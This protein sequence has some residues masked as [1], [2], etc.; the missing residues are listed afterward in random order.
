MLPQVNK[1]KVFESVQR[2]G[3]KK[4]V[5]REKGGKRKT[6]RVK[7]RLL[8]WR[9]LHDNFCATSSLANK[10]E[11]DGS[12]MYEC[13]HKKTQKNKRKRNKTK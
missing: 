4:N 8:L 1:L 11:A 9:P 2:K 10:K 6:F 12:F 5:K 3:K 13:A 7:V